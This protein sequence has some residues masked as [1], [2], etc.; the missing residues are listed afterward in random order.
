MQQYMLE[1]LTYIYYYF[2]IVSKFYFGVP[3]RFYSKVYLCA[4]WG[5]SIFI[6]LLFAHK[7]LKPVVFSKNYLLG[8]SKNRSSTGGVEFFFAKFAKFTGKHLC[9]SLFFNKVAG[10]HLCQSLFFI[11]RETPAQV[12]SCEFCKKFLEHLFHRTPP[13]GYSC[14]KL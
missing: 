11:K 1:C 2:T 13:N 14:K 5:R 6:S 8:N 12:F 3:S 9:Q 4:E 7:P 10:K